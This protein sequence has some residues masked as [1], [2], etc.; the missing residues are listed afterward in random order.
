MSAPKNNQYAKKD[1]T[2]SARINMLMYPETKAYLKEVSSGNI[3][4]YIK[5]LIQKDIDSNN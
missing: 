4:K 5:Q 3:S 1:K 2:E